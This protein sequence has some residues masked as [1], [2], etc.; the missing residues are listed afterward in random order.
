MGK[1]CFKMHKSALFL[2][3]A[4][5][6]LWAHSP[7]EGLEGESMARIARAQMGHV[8]LAG[9]A[10]IDASGDCLADVENSTS[11]KSVS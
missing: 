4:L 10:E 3:V 7:P 9:Q 5:D 2:I 11:R 1:Y 8:C 6:T